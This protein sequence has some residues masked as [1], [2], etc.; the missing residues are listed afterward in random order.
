MKIKNPAGRGGVAGCSGYRPTL[1][2]VQLRLDRATA[3]VKAMTVHVMA[4]AKHSAIAYL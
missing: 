1:D 3:E 4:A 2:H